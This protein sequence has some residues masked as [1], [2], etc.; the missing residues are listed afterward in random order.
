M[1]IFIVN[2]YTSSNAN[3]GQIYNNKVEAEKLVDRIVQFKSGCFELTTMAGKLS[4]HPIYKITSNV[5]ECLG[6]Y[7]SNQREIQLSK[8]FQTF[9]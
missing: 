7:M 4:A 2:H 9:T 6:I 1:A 8:I 3:F 5:E